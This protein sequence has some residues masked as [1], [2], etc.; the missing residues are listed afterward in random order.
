MAYFLDILAGAGLLLLAIG[1]Y[2]AFGLPWALI[3]IGALLLAAALLSGW[4][5]A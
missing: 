3:I 5:R 1:I 4:R 2:L